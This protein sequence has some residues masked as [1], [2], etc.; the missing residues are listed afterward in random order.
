VNKHEQ[1]AKASVEAEPLPL[2]HRQTI[3]GYFELIHPQIG[4]RDAV[5]K[6]TRRSEGGAEK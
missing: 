6:Q 5:L 3:R 1:L 4:K 2:G